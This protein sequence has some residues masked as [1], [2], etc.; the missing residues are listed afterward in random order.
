LERGGVP[1][2]A[3][4]V[5]I[6]TGHTVTYELADSRVSGVIIA[7]NAKLAFAPAKTAL[8]RTDK[9]ILVLGELEMK[10]SSA[11][12][13]HTIRFVEV[14]ELNFVGAGMNVVD[15][16]VGLWVRGDGLLDIAGTSKT[17][18]TRLQGGAN[19]GNSSIRLQ[20]APT[21]WRVGDE[22]SIVPTEPPTVGALLGAGLR[23]GL[24][25][26]YPEKSLP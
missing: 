6:A 24:S 21:G 15:T 16:D 13:H 3:D 1:D 22:I 5:T 4:A 11:P 23:Y 18:W 26:R 14:D 19:A 9:N 17:S 2:A 10:P 8:L 7:D 25:L 20:S 12:V